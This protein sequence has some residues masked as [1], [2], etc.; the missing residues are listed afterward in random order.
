LTVATPGSY[1]VVVTGGDGLS[2]TSTVAQ[3]IGTLINGTFSD[4]TGMGNQGGGWWAGLPVGW[5]GSSGALSFSVSSSSGTTPPLANLNVL[6][7]LSQ[8]VGTLTNNSDMVLKFDFTHPSGWPGASPVMSVLILTNSVVMA[9]NR[10]DYNSY[11]TKTV[12]ATNAPAGASLTVK[13]VSE[14]A[15]NAPALDNVSA[16]LINASY[17]TEIIQQP[18][19]LSVMI[20]GTV[21]VLSVGALGASPLSYQ[22]RSNNVA[23]SGANAA[24]LAV[25]KPGNYDVVVTGGNSTSVTSTVAQVVG[26]VLNGNFSDLTGLTSQGGGWYAGLPFGWTGSAGDYA[27]NSNLGATPPT[28]N[29]SQLG[30]LRQSVG[31]L[32]N[33]SDVVL[34]FDNNTAFANGS[35]WTL[36]VAILNSSLSPIVSSNFSPGLSQTLVASNVPPGTMLSIQFTAVA[37]FPGLDNVV[38]NASAVTPPAS[39]TLS[40]TA[41]GNT[42][43]LSWPVDASGFRLYGTSNLVPPVVW[44]P[45]TVFLRTNSQTISTTIPMGS[46]SRFYRLA[47]P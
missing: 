38:A 20:P 14:S 1:D 9:S 27:V 2:A 12:V 18:D 17:P 30:V 46:G 42:L 43:T 15:A 34:G 45:E 5:G 4:L 16:A 13:F 11:G 26:D 3:V 35:P 41:T 32:A 24:S 28:C 29:P 21:R 36:G 40:A 44:T 39:P 19:A 33:T 23:I 6:T 7:N 47:W 25:S 8:T 22:W 37:G 10:F 31:M